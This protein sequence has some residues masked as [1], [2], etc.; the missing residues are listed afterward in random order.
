VSASNPNPGDIDARLQFLLTG[1]ESLHVT[2]HEMTGPIQ[3]QTKQIEKLAE[4]SARH[5]RD[6]ARFNRAMGAALKAFLAEDE[7][8]AQ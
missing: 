3:E 5:E 7:G 1:T 8:G 4:T 6:N 2:V